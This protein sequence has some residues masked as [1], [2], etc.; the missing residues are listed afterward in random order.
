MYRLTD[1]LARHN[2]T[3]PGPIPGMPS[4]VLID[5]P[6][7]YR[8]PGLLLG[9]YYAVVIESDEEAD[10]LSAFLIAPRRCAVRPDLLDRRPSAIRSDA[11]LVMRL[12]PPQPG[13]PWIILCRWPDDFQS[14]K[15]SAK[16]DMAR[17]CYSFEAFTDA[18]SLE[19]QQL[20][21]LN[22]LAARGE[23]SIRLI[24]ADQMARTG[25]A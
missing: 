12:D 11:V 13:W 24:A 10:M 22:A 6:D 23:I 17:G 14:A 3:Y 20:E 21:I 4:V 18:A 9:R 1:D 19:A 7:G 5:L 16:I 15:A 25:I 8:G 2:L